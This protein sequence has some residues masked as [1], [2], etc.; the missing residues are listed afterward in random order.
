MKVDQIL[1]STVL[2]LCLLTLL[3]LRR[4]GGGIPADYEPKSM[5]HATLDLVD[6]S[7][8][9]PAPAATQL[10]ALTEQERTGY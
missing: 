10:P 5:K 8:D 2:S 4:G 6:F 3:S 1:I 7:S 9:L